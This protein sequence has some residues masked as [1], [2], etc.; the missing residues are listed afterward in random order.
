MTRVDPTKPY[1]DL[2]SLPPQADIETKAIL[3]Q[4]I[5]AR[6][7]LAE[8]KQAGE[9]IPNQAILINTIP[10][11]EAKDSSEIENVVTTTDKLFRFAQVDSTKADAATREALRY[12]T[13]LY[14]GY[15]SLK[16]KPLNTNTAITVCRTILGVD[17]DVRRVP[18][19][20]LAIHATGEVIYTPPAGEDLLRKKL[21]NW[22]QFQHNQRDID[23]LIRMA[24]AHYQFEAIHPFTDGN[25]RTGRVLNILFLVQEEL[26]NLPVLY[27]SHYIIRRRTD[28]YRLLREVTFNGQWEAWIL[29]MLEAVEVTSRWTR[30]KISAVRRLMD[31]TLE[32][33]KQELP[34]VYSYE[35][36][37]LTFTQPYCRITNLVDAEIAKR[38][39]ASEYLKKLCDIGV[40]SEKAVGREKIFINTKL[41]E[42]L[43][44]DANDF[45]PYKV[46]SN[47]T[48]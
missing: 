26:L 32:Y 41:V 2:P 18:G 45:A 12:R 4:C 43:L 7:A 36:V 40:L 20:A 14:E 21:A 33:I 42:L 10:L 35:L 28:Y 38:E 34:R 47:S 11:L 24:V 1:N 15:Q 17:V 29:Y 44:K 25:G 46:E 37:E 30:G 9:L 48:H 27:L 8:L 3:K 6:S 19:T 39:T 23:P 16:G 22:E 13:A 31:H 5:T